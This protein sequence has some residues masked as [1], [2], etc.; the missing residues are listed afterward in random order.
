MSGKRERIEAGIILLS[1]FLALCG[2]AGSG[3]SRFSRRETVPE[4]ITVRVVEAVSVQ[5]AGVA[6]Y[7]GTVESTRRTLISSPASGTLARVLCREGGKVESGDLLAVVESPVLQGAYDIAKARL[8][9]AEDGWRRI[10]KL[11]ESGSVPEVKVVEVQAAL[12]QAQAAELSARE[13]LEE[14]R[15]K[16]PFS[17]AVEKVFV[18]SG[19]KMMPGEAIL[20]LVDAKAREIRF[21][22]PENEYSEI[23]EGMPAEVV[24]PAVNATVSGVVA[25]KGVS[26]SRLSHSYECVVKM[27]GGHPDI[28]P[29]MVCRILVSAG[30]ETGIVVPASAVSTDM[31]GYCVWVVEN[32][33]VGKRSVV[34]GGFSG[35][36]VVIES[37]I[38]PG[39][40]VITEGATKV[41]VGMKVK[42][43]R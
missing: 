21:Q 27:H 8:A 23:K 24:V 5:E 7:V 36:G 25:S 26:A 4:E 38:A 30:G 41:S 37:G 17:A 31:K 29:G 3:Q 18:S 32:G 35:K 16:A 12:S 20:E 15:I 34:T 43:V 2:C 11:K 10:E 28:V 1:S 42:A 9:Q 33:I 40:L 19:M 14:C 22:I 13:A 39:D 6:R